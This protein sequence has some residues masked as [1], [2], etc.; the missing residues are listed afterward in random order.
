MQP[1]AV[2]FFAQSAFRC[3]LLSQIFLLECQSLPLYGVGA[4]CGMGL[5]EISRHAKLK[6]TAAPCFFMFCVII[7]NKMLNFAFD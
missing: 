3:R 4:R 6:V 5:K 2:K 7:T 1:S